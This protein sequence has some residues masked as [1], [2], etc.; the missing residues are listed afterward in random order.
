MRTSILQEQWSLAP[1]YACQFETAQENPGKSF[2][3]LR[4]NSKKSREFSEN[5]FL[6]LCKKEKD[7]PEFSE[8]PGKKHFKT[9]Q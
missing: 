5:Y 4:I 3:F 1:S 9:V 8:I 7:S 2:E 6:F